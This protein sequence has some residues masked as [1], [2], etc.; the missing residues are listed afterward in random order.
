[1]ASSYLESMSKSYRYILKS[2]EQELVPLADELQFI[3]TYIHLQKVR[4]EEALK[5]ETDIAEDFNHFKIVPVT[6]QNLIENAIKHNIVDI[7]S[8]LIVRI[9]EE[10]GY[11]VVENNLQRKSFVETSNKRGLNDLISLYKYLDNRPV[12]VDETENHFR[13]WVPLV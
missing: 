2:Q 4:F 12:K 8:P 9:F 7:D 1:M 11:L 6:L 3:Q 10:N 5:V 13:I